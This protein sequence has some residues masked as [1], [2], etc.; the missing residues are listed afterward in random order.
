MVGE[1]KGIE[2]MGVLVG[3]AVCSRHQGSALLNTRGV[4]LQALWQQ[5]ISALQAVQISSGF[6][7]H[8]LLEMCL[9]CITGFCVKHLVV[10]RCSRITTPRN[11]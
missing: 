10:G 5:E 11:V 9:G 1:V 4:R 7:V 6:N 3:N 2:M 8:R